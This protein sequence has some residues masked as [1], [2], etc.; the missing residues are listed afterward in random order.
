MRTFDLV[1][2]EFDGLLHVFP[3]HTIT[4]TVIIIPYSDII[5]YLFQKQQVL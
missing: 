5:V 2:G 1:I 4:Y 3:V